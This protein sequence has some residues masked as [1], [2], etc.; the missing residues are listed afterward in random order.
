MGSSRFKIRI[1]QGF[2]LIELLV[3]IVLL[4]IMA[5]GAGMLISRPI[6]AYVDQ[7]RR[8]ELVDLAEMSLRKIA[9]DIRAALPN[10]IRVI[11]NGPTSWTLEMVNTVDG[12]RYR[13]QAGPGFT[14]PV[15]RLSFTGDTE[16]NVL[17]LFSTLPTTGLPI[18]YADYRVVIYNTRNDGPDS[19]YDHAALNKNPGIISPGN[20]AL[21][22]DGIEHHLTLPSSFQFDLQSP[23]QRLFLVDGPVSYVCDTSSNSLTR[24]SGYSYT[25][26]QSSVPTGGSSG[27]ITSKVSSC[28]ILYDEGSSQRGGL[29]SIDL[30]LSDPKGGTVRLMHQVHVDNV[31]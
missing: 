6:E 30:T 11:D 25:A 9:T 23:S 16:F 19:I 13:D 27:R 14:D 5:A 10:S 12:A 18:T 22:L 7:T 15:D 3:V 1:G 28:N 29:V 8:Q 31:P 20:I 24:Y 17:G 2:S 4:G 26:A 21:D